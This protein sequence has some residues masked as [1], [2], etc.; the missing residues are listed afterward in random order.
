MIFAGIFLTGVGIVLLLN[1][2]RGE[3][4]TS[5]PGAFL[6]SVGILILIWEIISHGL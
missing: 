4:C 2:W 5:K 3:P 6:F 1:P